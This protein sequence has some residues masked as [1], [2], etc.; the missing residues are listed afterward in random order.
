MDALICWLS[1]A[2]L[3]RCFMESGLTKS[4]T[5]CNFCNKVAMMIIFFFKMF[6]IYVDSRDGINKWEKVF[7]FKDSI[8][9]IGNDKFSQSLTGYLSLTINMLRRSPK[10]NIYLWEIFSKSGS[11][12]VIKEYDESALIQM[13][14]L[15]FCFKSCKFSAAIWYVISNIFGSSRLL[16][17]LH[18]K[19]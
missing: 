3:K 8:I 16:Y 1:K 15:V 14:Y 2:L 4:F 7:G 13:K 12:R 19:L 11:S 9:W 10:I 17:S 18:F 6:N 5:I